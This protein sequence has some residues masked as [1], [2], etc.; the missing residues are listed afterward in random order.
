[1][2]ETFV[3]KKKITLKT[4]G[5]IFTTSIIN[6][7]KNF[8]ILKNNETENDPCIISKTKSDL[9]NFHKF[10]ATY[11]GYNTNNDSLLVYHDVGTGKTSKIIFF[12]NM[13]YNSN[14]NINIFIFIKASLRKT[15]DIEIGKWLEKQNYEKRK[16]N[17]YFVNFDSP[18]SHKNFE[19]IKK[20]TDISNKN[21][22]IIDECH[23]FISRVLSNIRSNKKRT[24]AI[25][26]EIIKDKKENN[27]KI[28]CMSATPAV[29]EPFELGLLFNL[30]RPDIFPKEETLFNKL[31][32]DSTM[33]VETLNYKMKN[34]F[35][36]RIIGLVSYYKPGSLYG[37]YA[38]KIVKHENIEMSEYQTEKY[39]YFENYEKEISKSKN[40]SFTNSTYRAYVRRASNFVFPN[41]SELVNNENRPKPST[42]QIST[43][44][45]EVLMKGKEGEKKLDLTS[46]QKAYVKIL[47][48]FEKEVEKYFDNI[49]EK[50]K[51]TKNNIENDI[52]NFKKHETYADYCNNEKEKS[53]LIK[54]LMKCS[55]K[56]M[57][58]IFNIFKSS[59]PVICY[60]NY[61][62]L[63]GLHMLKIYLKYFGF[64]KYSN[65]K[66]KDYFRYGEFTGDASSADRNS[67]IEIEQSENNIEGKLIK[68]IFFSSAGAEGITM[69]NIEQIHIIEP[70]W[71]EARIEQIIGRG[72]RFCSHKQLPIEKRIVTVYRYISKRNIK[73]MKNNKNYNERQLLTVD[74]DIEKVSRNKSNLLESFYEA[75][76][77]VAVDCELF[78]NDNMIKNKYKCF[79]FD[80]QSLFDINIGP[81][82]RED[83]NEDIKMSNGSNSL[84]SISL[85]IKVIKINGISDSG[86]KNTFWY[87]VES[88]VIYDYDFH[89]AVGK[90][91]K[92]KDGY[93]DKI[94]NDTYKIDV[95]EIPKI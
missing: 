57:A 28:I 70:F 8:V 32:I 86:E 66:S 40:N 23:L 73:V 44:I 3:K 11:L 45:L 18:Y 75:M 83:I 19:T 37:V 9:Q 12:L 46:E 20:T 60:L 90:V 26:E 21:I 48:H 49:N 2:D 95:I 69:Y 10:I 1:M 72:I 63:E 39:N 74:S 34:L 14:P 81:A 54:E 51:K 36:R 78:K 15:W 82:Y 31:F 80:E 65:D 61:I 77:E 33:G 89:Y 93:P 58:T 71:N 24:S 52:E 92:G 42:F 53:N 76:K 62:L 47:E 56:Y 94:D 59:G 64:L 38:K 29:N 17:I 55:C 87:S 68:I 13:I 30:L 5:R 27:C 79:K 41:V 84:N 4:N 43:K 88:G 6:N 16:E 7:Y 22:Y 25:Y 67:V 35:Q 91:K 85:R 50:D